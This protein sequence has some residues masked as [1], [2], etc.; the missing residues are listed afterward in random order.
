[1]GGVASNQK[2]LSICVVKRSLQNNKSDCTH[3]EKKIFAME[4]VDHSTL[5]IIHST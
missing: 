5:Q 2:L 4:L 1:M 3:Q